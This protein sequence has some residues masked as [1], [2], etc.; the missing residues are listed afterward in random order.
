MA[1]VLFTLIALMLRCCCCC[2]FNLNVE[3][4]CESVYRDQM[5]R[6]ARL[7]KMRK[8]DFFFWWIESSP[9]DGGCGSLCEHFSLGELNCNFCAVPRNLIIN[10]C[11]LIN[12]ISKLKSTINVHTSTTTTTTQKVWIEIE[13]LQHSWWLICVVEISIKFDLSI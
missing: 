2:Y 6:C 7:V 13:C 11:Q 8:Y 10:T 12:V 5:W 1:Y 3:R 9:D 4:M